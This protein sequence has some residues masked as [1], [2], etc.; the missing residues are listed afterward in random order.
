MLE[1]ETLTGVDTKA[2]QALEVAADT[3]AAAPTRLQA[4]IL[5]AARKGSK[6][7]DITR[8]IRHVYTYDYVARLIRQDKS[9]NPGLY[10]R[11]ARE[12]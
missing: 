10:R 5:D 9:A 12:S 6:P 8:A 7:A 2:R 3:Y 4:A 11:A 1:R